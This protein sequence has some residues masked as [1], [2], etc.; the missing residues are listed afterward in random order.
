VRMPTIVC[1]HG[2]RFA[3]RELI[4]RT[5]RQGGSGRRRSTFYQPRQSFDPAG[6]NA[7]ASNRGLAPSKRRL[8]ACF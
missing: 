7:L 2:K 5:I 1:I 8:D 3:G 6:S 4:T